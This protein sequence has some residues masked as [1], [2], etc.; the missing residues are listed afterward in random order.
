MRVITITISGPV[1][2]IDGYME[3]VLGSLL[4]QDLITAREQSVTEERNGLTTITLTL[5]LKDPL[6]GNLGTSDIRQVREDTL[7]IGARG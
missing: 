6:L 4:V 5:T 3:I 1:G 7:R 2:Q